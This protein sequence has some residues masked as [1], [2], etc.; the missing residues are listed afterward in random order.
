MAGG[1]SG[2]ATCQTIKWLAVSCNSSGST[3]N[4]NHTAAFFCALSDK[5]HTI[6]CVCFFSNIFWLFWQWKNVLLFF[7]LLKIP[8]KK[9]GIATRLKDSKDCV[10][11]MVPTLTEV[12]VTFSTGQD[13]HRC[14]TRWRRGQCGHFSWLGNVTSCCRS[15]PLSWNA[16]NKNYK[17][18]KF[19]GLKK[20]GK[21]TWNSNKEFD[22]IFVTMERELRLGHGA[23][24]NKTAGHH[25]ISGIATISN[26]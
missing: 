26:H 21:I 20:S 15:S 5:T 14:R 3:R 25:S 23:V 17:L 9:I 2:R 19:R 22:C 6:F 13:Q 1:W 11:W 4:T 18:I 8:T 7:C 10:K 12:D 24:R 16:T